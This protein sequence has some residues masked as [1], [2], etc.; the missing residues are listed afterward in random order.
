MRLCVDR[1]HGRRGG[2]GCVARSDEL[3]PSPRSRLSPYEIIAARSPT[4]YQ[5]VGDG[6]LVTYA[7]QPDG[8]RVALAAVDQT[9]IRDKVVFVSNFLEYLKKIAPVKK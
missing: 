3:S 1:D 7:L 5:G 6:E 9:D 8:K 4:G 2:L